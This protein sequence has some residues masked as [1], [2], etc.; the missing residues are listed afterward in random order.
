MADR[1]KIFS[2]KEAT[3]L[4]LKA[5]KLQ[6]EQPEPDSQD[7]VPGITLDELKRMAKELGVEERYLVKALESEGKYSPVKT[8]QEKKGGDFLGIPWV[9]EYEAVLDGELPLEHFDVVM[10]DMYTSHGKGRQGYA[11]MPT[12]VGRTVQGQVGAGL[13][14]GRFTMTSRNGRT[15]MNVRSNA[16]VPF[17]AVGYPIFI[18]SAIISA[19]LGENSSL[20]G[21]AIGLFVLAALTFATVVSASLAKVGHQKLKE[22]FESM[23]RKVDE[24]TANLREN[25]RD[26]ESADEDVVES[27][28]LGLRDRLG[29]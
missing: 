13:G 17:M 22:K 29:E 21:W 16:F 25:L 2:E 10:E 9:R 6:E 19:V 11:M 3:D 20:P 7:Y 26:S 8:E 24:E 12:Q 1:K 23:V 28:R 4:M 15:R 14:Y 18:F 5:A 27:V